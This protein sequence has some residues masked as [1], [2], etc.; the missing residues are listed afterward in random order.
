[1]ETAY[2]KAVFNQYYAGLGAV[3]TPL[4]EENFARYGVSS[5]PT[6]VL[7]DAAGIVRLYNPGNVS[8]AVLAR[9]IE[10]LLPTTR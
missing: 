5:T 3:E 8:Y 9:K 10:G 6:M 2:I 7:V 1:M 4:S